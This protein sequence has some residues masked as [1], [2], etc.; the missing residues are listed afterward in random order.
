MNAQLVAGGFPSGSN[1][2]NPNI[3]LVLVEHYTSVEQSFDVNCDGQTDMTLTLS[4]GFTPGDGSNNLHLKVSDTST[5]Q[6]LMDTTSTFS[7]RPKFYKVNDAINANSFF[8]YVAD[9]LF[10]LGSF[11]GFCQNCIQNNLDYKDLY[12]SYK[13]KLSNGSFV[14][15]W[16]K[17]SYYLFDAYGNSSSKNP[18]TA[19]INEALIYCS[20]SSS[21]V[22][23]ESITEKNDL[24]VYKN[25]VYISIAEDAIDNS[26]TIQIINSAGVT[27]FIKQAKLHAGINTFSIP[28]NLTNGLYL[29][30]VFNADEKL[31]IKTM[32]GD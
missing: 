31:K 17:L 15:G 32:I 3:D 14:K 29:I 27:V 8:K 22:K 16:I 13:Q 6:I 1:S 9:T 5:F 4:K 18:I 12:F 23:E 11:G 10:V 25:D 2:S 24:Y 26:F 7:K 19:S 28:D 21:S 30:W 20:V